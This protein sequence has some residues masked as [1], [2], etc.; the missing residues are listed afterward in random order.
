VARDEAFHFYY[1]ENLALLESL[2]AELAYFSPLRDPALPEGSQGLLIGGGF[3]E[4]FGKTLAENWPLLLQ[5]KQRI[6]EGLP[7]WA[8]CGG[9]MW[10]AQKLV[11][12]EGREHRLVGALEASTQMTARLQ[13]FGYTQAK[14]GAGHAFLPKGLRLRGHEFHHSQWQALGTPRS[15]WTL[16][17]TGRPKRPEG[18]RLPGGVASYFHAYLPAAPKAAQAFA[19]ACR[20]QVKA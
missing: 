20:K 14:V 3:P 12:L 7:I 5:V 9:L 18:W 11:D 2:G 1:P 19:A 13:H 15:S 8:E 17:Q 6:A 16:S 4:I 10:L